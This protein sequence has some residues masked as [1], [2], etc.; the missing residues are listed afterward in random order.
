M[1]YFLSIEQPD[2]IYFEC[3]ECGFDS[4][5]KADFDGDDRCPMCEGDSGHVVHMRQR[6][7]R[8]RDQAEGFDARN[9]TREEQEEQWLMMMKQSKGK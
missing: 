8:D 9:G 1:I 4:I 6:I 7:C 5:Q 3:P 2:Y